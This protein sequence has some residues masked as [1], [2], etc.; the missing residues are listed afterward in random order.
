M[1]AAHDDY[2]PSTV[3]LALQHPKLELLTSRTPEQ[4]LKFV[5]TRGKKSKEHLSELVLKNIAFLES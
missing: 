3:T 2:K 5:E 4:L 1:A